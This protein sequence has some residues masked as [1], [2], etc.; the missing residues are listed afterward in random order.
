VMY[1]LG[2]LWGM[3]QLLL[4]LSPVQRQREPWPGAGRKSA[5]PK[6][7]YEENT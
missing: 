5:L 4:H 7:G 3:L 6:T 1:G 2:T